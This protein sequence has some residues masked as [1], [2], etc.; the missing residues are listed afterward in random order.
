M[1]TADLQPDADRLRAMNRNRVGRY[2][3]RHPNRR[4]VTRLRYSKHLLEAWGFSVSEAGSID[5]TDI[6]ALDLLPP[7]DG[8]MPHDNR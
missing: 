7:I 5:L 6:G 4:I 8:M 2:Y 1:S 3:G